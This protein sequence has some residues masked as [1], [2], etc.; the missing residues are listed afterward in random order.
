M[1]GKADAQL[2]LRPHKCQHFPCVDSLQR[3]FAPRPYLGCRS[4][5]FNCSVFSFV[6]SGPSSIAAASRRRNPCRL[7]FLFYPHPVAADNHDTN[8][9]ALKPWAQQSKA[10]MRIPQSYIQKVKVAAHVFQGILVFVTGC[11]TISVLARS[12]PAGGG[13]KFTMA[14]V[15]YESLCNG[16][17]ASANK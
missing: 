15:S 16:K 3:S 17:L 14:L 12:G 8:T 5:K 4:H 2:R 10:K 9:A 6:Q 13:T 1:R 11:L 7:R